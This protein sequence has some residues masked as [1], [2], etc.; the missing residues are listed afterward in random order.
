MSRSTQPAG[1]REDGGGRELLR[2]AVPLI[3]SNGFLTL[4]VTLD[5]IMLSRLD[6][7]AVGAVLP[8]VMLFWTA[9]ALVQ[10]T[11]NYATTFVAQYVGAGRPHRAGPALW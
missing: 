4:Q 8:A 7:D 1:W 11:A 5:R 6:S 10:N 9:F 3:L 2:L